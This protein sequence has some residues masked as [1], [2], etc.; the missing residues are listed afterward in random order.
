MGLPINF[1]IGPIRYRAPLTSS[2]RRRVGR[3]AAAQYYQPQSSS[4]RVSLGVAVAMGAG[5][6]LVGII[7]GLVF[8][9]ASR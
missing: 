4:G 6:L 2:R 8:A 1:G 7:L 3:P 5:G 9:V